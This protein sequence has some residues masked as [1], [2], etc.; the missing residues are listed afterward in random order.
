MAEREKQLEFESRLS[1]LRSAL[2]RE[3]KRLERLLSKLAEEKQAACEAE[4]I[5]HWGEVIK[6]NLGKIP[7]EKGKEDRAVGKKEIT[8]ADPYNPGEAVTIPLNPALSVLE[9]M[10]LLFQKYKKLRDSLPHVESRYN[11]C[12]RRIA[13]LNDVL[14]QLDSLSWHCLLYTSPSPRD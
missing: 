4:K 8:L 3:K 13:E 7:I 2:R 5:K 11:E 10:N 14:A 6:Y 9:N 1:S 12:S